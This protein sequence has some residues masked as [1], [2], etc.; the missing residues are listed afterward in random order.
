MESCTSSLMSFITYP[1]GKQWVPTCMYSTCVEACMCE[2]TAPS[3]GTMRQGYAYHEVT[4][5]RA[6][7]TKTCWGYP[8]RYES[9]Q[10]SGKIAHISCKRDRL[11]E[12]RKDTIVQVKRDKALRTGCLLAVFHTSVPSYLLTISLTLAS[13]TADAP[14]LSMAITK[15]GSVSSTSSSLMPV[16]RATTRRYFSSSS[17]LLL[18]S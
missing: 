9:G 13:S 1:Q 5:R 3:I 7:L 14:S 10:K 6:K 16:H 8:T 4:G 17:L 15:P 2:V 18:R 11:S 12:T